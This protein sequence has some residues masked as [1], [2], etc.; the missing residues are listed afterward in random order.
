MNQ[1]REIFNQLLTK[2]G[3][4]AKQVCAWS[5]LHESR[6]SRFR[7]GRLDLEA[8]EFFR[9]VESLPQEAQDFFWSQKKLKS[10]SLKE[11]I[12]TA[13]LDEIVAADLLNAIASSLRASN[14]GNFTAP[15]RGKSSEA[16]ALSRFSSSWDAVPPS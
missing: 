14:S 4:S 3:Y 1:H 11:L 13:A 8:G 12:A 7:T 2:F 15:L 10:L 6:L 5:G 16:S 9:L